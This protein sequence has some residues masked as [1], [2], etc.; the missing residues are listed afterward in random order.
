MALVPNEVQFSVLILTIPSRVE[1][2]WTPLYQHLEKQIADSRAKVEV[3]TLADNKVMTIGEKRQALLDISRGKWIGFLDDDD[4]VSDDY[5]ASLSRA[6]NDKP[7]D[8]ITFEQDCT[9]NSD[10]F[11][12]DFRVG[13]PV[14]PYVPNS[15][16]TLIRRPPYHICFWR[17]SIAKKARFRSLSYGEDLDWIS[18]ILPYVTL[19]THLDKVLH[20]YRYSDSTSESVQYAKH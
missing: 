14:E 11:K 19:E 7:A 6:M 2:Y 1:K 18:R 10:K 12:V 13:N 16:K 15:G 9:V 5:I 4:W 8:V 17:S 3:L 20:E